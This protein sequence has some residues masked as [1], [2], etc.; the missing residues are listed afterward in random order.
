VVRAVAD[1]SK[2]IERIEDAVAGRVL[3]SLPF[4]LDDLLSG[5]RYFF[6]NESALGAQV[7]GDW[8]QWFV[9]AVSATKRLAVLS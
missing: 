6:G 5:F 1:Q 2:R 8:F 7:R 4:R 3:H 9:G